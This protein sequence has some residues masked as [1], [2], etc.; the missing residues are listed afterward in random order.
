MSKTLILLFH[1]GPNRSRANAALAAAAASLPGVEV[2]DIHA[3]Y[4]DGRIDIDREVARLLSADRIVFQFPIQW[5]SAPPV[6]KAW[7]NAVLTR[8]YYLAY[9]TEGR[10]LEGR[11]L[12]VAATAGN[13]PEAYGPGG[14]NAFTMAELLRPLEATARRCGLLWQAPFLLFRADRL[15]D[16]ALHGAARDYAAL[17]EEWRRAGEPA[18]DPRRYLV[19]AWG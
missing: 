19:E 7:E 17:L 13:V 3:L 4:P 9:E 8:M 5:Y 16:L 12:L 14:A 18:E 15:D 6:L 10:L 1:S 11:P 2:A